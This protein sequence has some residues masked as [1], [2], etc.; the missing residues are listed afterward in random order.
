MEYI[1][2]GRGPNHH[3]RHLATREKRITPL[4]GKRFGRLVVIGVGTK[5]SSKKSQGTYALCTCDCGKTVSVHAKSMEHGHIFSCGCFG[6]LSASVRNSTHGMRNSAEYQTW[7]D[8]VRRCHNP[9]RKAFYRY[10]G[11]GIQ[12][13][14]EWRESFETFLAHVGRRPS[15][16]LTLDRI[17]N[18]GN[19][20]PGNVRWA[21]RKE[22]AN[23]RRKQSPRKTAR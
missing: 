9:S 11:R 18:D 8:M 4:I 22:Q 15:A 6:S 23:N 19:Y 7:I 13:C 21:T 1:G 3:A 2:K 20:E 5:P 16:S 17:D 14:A 12:V 10:G